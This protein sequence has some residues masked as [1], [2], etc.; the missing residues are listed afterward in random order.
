MRRGAKGVSWG[1]AIALVLVLASPAVRAQV[2]GRG[3]LVGFIFGQDGSTPVAGAVVL[4]KNLTTGA[5]TE[6]A[7]SDELGVFKVPGLSPGLY[8][9]GVRSEAGSYNSQDFFGVT[10]EKTAKIA[11]ALNPYDAVSAAAAAAVIKEQRDK[12]EAYIGK[13][14]KYNPETKEAEILIEIG[15]IQAEDRIHIK[16]QAT[17]FYQDMKGL[18]AYGTRTKRVTSG[19]TAVIRTSKPCQEGDFVYIVC[20]RGVPPF[21]LAPL[22]IAAIV[23]GAVPLSATFEEEPVSPFGI[24]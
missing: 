17:D 18:K 24:R 15:L 5:V 8:A 9:L 22:G 19:Y 6:A 4:V 20:K 10:A 16:G 7:G 3:N 13:V 1:S 14:V 12:G 2:P 21:F 23:A 11:I